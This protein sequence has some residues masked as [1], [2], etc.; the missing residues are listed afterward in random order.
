MPTMSRFALLA[1]S[2]LIAQPAAAQTVPAD[3]ASTSPNPAGT[4]SVGTGAS[5]DT[6]EIIVTARH[7]AESSQAVPLAISVIGGDHIDNTGAFNVGRLQ[8]LTPTLQFYSS[9]PRN[10]S[11]NIRGIGA[12]VGLTNDGIEQGV[13]IYVDD[14]YSSRVASATFDFLDVQRIE[15]LRGPQGTLYGKN[16]TAGAINIATRQPTFQFEGRAE[17]SFGN[18]GFKQAKAALSGPLTG[19][20]AARIAVSATSRNGTLYNVTPQRRVNEQANLGVR[21]Q[22]LWRPTGDLDVTLSGDYNTQ[23]PECCATVYVRTAPTQRPIYRQFDAL[24]AAQGYTA[25]SRNPFDRV[26]DVDADLNAGNKI[27]GLSAKAKLGLGAATLTSITAWRFWD[28]MPSNDRDFTA[29]PVT[30]KS[31]NPSRQNQYTQ[32]FRFAHSGSRLDV[33]AGL[34]GYYQTIRT[35]GLQQ[36]GLSASRWLLNPGNISATYL[37]NPSACAT[38]TTRACDPAVLN[39]LTSTNTIN[40]DSTSLAFYGQLGWKITDQFTLQPGVRVNY[41]RK[42]GLYRAV[43]TDGAGALV[44]FNPANTPTQIDQLSQMAPEQFAPRYAAWNVSYDLTAKYDLTSDI[45]LYATFA[46]SF[47]SGGINLNG[48]PAAAD[49]TP[50]LQYATVKPERV[51]HAELGLKTQ[52]AERT[53]TVNL[54]AFRTDIRDYQAIVNNGAVSALRGYVDNAGLV[55]T[56]GF[57]WDASW[58]PGPRFNAYLNGGYTD[59]KYLRFSNA[60]CPPELSGGGSGSPLGMAGTAG[61]NSPVS[62]DISGQTLPGISK[63]S[64]SYGAEANVP[65]KL[66]GHSGE[67]YL[68]IEGNYRS[69]F[70]SNASQSAH[71][72]IAGYALTNLRLGFRTKAGL[73]V[74]GWVRNAFDVHYF[75]L[76]QIAPGSTGLI[77]G[78]L[79]DPRTF[80]GTVKVEF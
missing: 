66:M 44:T 37:T 17:L 51:N 78:S 46:H 72:G 23:N 32:E 24:A 61:T 58:R 73:N 22:L 74:F 63:W 2:A 27:G 42:H 34:F 31:Q 7:K 80:G 57:E 76:L 41:D 40:L 65:T 48:V 64:L 56:Q 29:L 8:Q 55:R 20:L 67:L 6:P 68:G 49:G 59:A 21:V 28:W 11:V 4:T 52:F 16:T 19:N 25:A 30:T 62:C 12:P 15:V 47:K 69:D 53:I 39:G 50:L 38:P 43:V 1:T 26:T 33:N 14:V 60:P 3:P 35:Q 10:S 79:G 45:H 70:S 18:L 75:E 5:D 77:V 71:T 13:G 36:L 54:A 9:N